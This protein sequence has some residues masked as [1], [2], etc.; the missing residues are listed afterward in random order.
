[1]SFQ[2]LP[3]VRA[4][5]INIWVSPF[6]LALANLVLLSVDR[7]AEI[8]IS[9]NQSSNCIASLSLKIVISCSKVFVKFVFFWTEHSVSV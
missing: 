2:L 7:S 1:M 9:V 8:S 6:D 4:S 5:V 3:D